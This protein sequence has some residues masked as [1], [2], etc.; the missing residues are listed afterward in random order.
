MPSGAVGRFLSGHIDLLGTATESRDVSRSRSPAAAR[1]A[2][3]RVGCPQRTEQ[4]KRARVNSGASVHPHARR[5][6][7]MAVWV[8]GSV[9]QWAVVRSEPAKTFRR[10]SRQSLSST[11]IRMCPADRIRAIGLPN[12]LACARPRRKRVRRVRCSQSHVLMP[13]ATVANRSSI[14]MR[15]EG[16]TAN[17]KP[18]TLAPRPLTP[19]P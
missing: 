2:Q 7:S 10:R 16:T 13:R 3:G 15:C 1:P 5:I 18:Q 9:G 11:R 6:P 4:W 19:A 8:C 12:G 17:L 14:G